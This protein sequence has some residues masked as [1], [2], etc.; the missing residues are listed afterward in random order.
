[1]IFENSYVIHYLMKS[2]VL[3]NSK[4]LDMSSICKKYN[5]KKIEVFLRP[6]GLIQQ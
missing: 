6:E 4:K 5:I 3:N 1:M 2:H